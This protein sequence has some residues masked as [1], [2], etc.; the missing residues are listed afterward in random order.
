MN[1][2]L[3]K[4]AG[5]LSFVE[6]PESAGVYLGFMVRNVRAEGFDLSGFTSRKYLLI[7]VTIITTMRPLITI[8]IY[9]KGH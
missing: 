5:F 1:K 2:G 4:S 7:F 9:T 3:Y 6:K 8:T